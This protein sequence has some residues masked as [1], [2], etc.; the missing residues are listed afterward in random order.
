M[1]KNIFLE[2]GFLPTYNI[3][4]IEGTKLKIFTENNLD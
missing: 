3:K 4:K 1:L 2:T